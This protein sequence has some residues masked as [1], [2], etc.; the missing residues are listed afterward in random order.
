MFRTGHRTP[1]TVLVEVSVI[2]AG[3]C[4]ESADG[5]TVAKLKPVEV[6]MRERITR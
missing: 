1:F 3:V 6:P 5:G 2:G 4:G